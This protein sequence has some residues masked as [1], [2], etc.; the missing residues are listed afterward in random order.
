MEEMAA[1]RPAHL[2]ARGAYDAPGEIV[3]RD[4]PSACRPSPPT[5]RATGW[6]WRAG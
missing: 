5:S 6:G 1:P 4:T 2:L 3:P